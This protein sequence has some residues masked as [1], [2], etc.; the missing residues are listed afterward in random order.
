MFFLFFFEKK[1]EKR[2]K[3]IEKPMEFYSALDLSL[4]NKQVL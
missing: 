1:K 4:N 3:E 2:K